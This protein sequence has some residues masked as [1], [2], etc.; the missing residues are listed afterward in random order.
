M[1]LFYC[2]SMIA[3]NKSTFRLNTAEDNNH[4]LEKVSSDDDGDSQICKEN[5]QNLNGYN[6]N[7]NCIVK[8]K[9]KFE[10]YN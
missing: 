10:L 3:G 1:N 6:L 8:I 2:I 7:N 9:I 5:K 4:W